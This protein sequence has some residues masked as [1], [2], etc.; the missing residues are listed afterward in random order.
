MDML[1][2]WSSFIKPFYRKIFFEP[3]LN[4]TTFCWASEHFMIPLD[5]YPLQ[6]DYAIFGVARDRKSNWLR[7][8]KL[9]SPVN[10][11]KLSDK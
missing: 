4:F 7:P 8:Q 2:Q 5:L 9:A 3:F 10:I 6:V 1:A 11:Q